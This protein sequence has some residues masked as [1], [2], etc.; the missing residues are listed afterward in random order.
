MPKNA[1]KSVCIRLSNV[2]FE[3]LR[4]LADSNGDNH[5]AAASKLV[6]NGLQASKA[7]ELVEKRFVDLERKLT[8]ATFAMLTILVN[9]DEQGRIE[10]GEKV[11]ELLKGKG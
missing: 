3:C 7:E 8:R 10:Y 5:T 1:K 2:E 9:H 6:V 11:N 4:E